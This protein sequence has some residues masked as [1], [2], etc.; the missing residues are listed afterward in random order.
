MQVQKD[1]AMLKSLAAGTNARKCIR[2]AYSYRTFSH[3][4]APESVTPPANL[5]D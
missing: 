5:E 1:E 3:T 2:Y 4:N